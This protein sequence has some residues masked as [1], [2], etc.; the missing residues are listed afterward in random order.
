MTDGL[1]DV[2]ELNVGGRA[3]FWGRHFFRVPV[4]T[5]FF[6]FVFFFRLGVLF[7]SKS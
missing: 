5:A 1:D 4:D 2:I 7:F 6:L 3:G